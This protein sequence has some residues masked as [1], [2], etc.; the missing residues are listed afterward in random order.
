MKRSDA[1]KLI[2][3]ILMF[4]L[5]G[6]PLDKQEKYKNESLAS[7]ILYELEEAGM[8]PPYVNKSKNKHLGEPFYNA[9]YYWELEDEKK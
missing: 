6:L 3:K 4:G 5:Q 8:L 2:G 7:I 9:D 1:E